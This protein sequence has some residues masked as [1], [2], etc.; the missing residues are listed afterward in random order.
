M[1]NII[2]RKDETYKILTDDLLEHCRTI[3]GFSDKIICNEHEK[4][5][6]VAVNGRLKQSNIDELL[7]NYL[8]TTRRKY[9]KYFIESIF[10]T[11]DTNNDGYVDF[12]EYLMSIRFFQT[13]SPVEKA[14]FI[15]RMIDK[16]G[17]NLVSRKELEMILL[18]LAKYHKSLSNEYVTNL[19]D[20]SSNSAADIVFKKLDEDGS[21]LISVSEFVDGWLKDETVRA[22]FNF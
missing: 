2:H 1:G 19:I 17:D 13:K 12:A 22:L 3:T 10:S 16:N 7:V 11:I 5:F 18:C 20:D 4:F 8:P 21:G 6:S 15:F 14:N 9:T